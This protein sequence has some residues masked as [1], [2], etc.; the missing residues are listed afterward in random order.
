MNYIQ[1]E[2]YE[3]IKAFFKEEF[4]N[5]IISEKAKYI[6]LEVTKLYRGII[7]VNINSKM[8]NTRMFMEYFVEDIEGIQLEHYLLHFTGE[9]SLTINDVLNTIE[10]KYHIL[11]N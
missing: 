8:N 6:T 7:S 4:E 5:Q 11:L 3:I 2:N 10:T 9:Q 1:I